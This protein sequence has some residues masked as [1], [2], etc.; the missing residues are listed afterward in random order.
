MSIIVRIRRSV[1]DKMKEYGAQLVGDCKKKERRYENR[2]TSISLR[3][4]NN[5]ASRKD[6]S[7]T[8]GKEL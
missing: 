6:S 5:W 8:P 2:K 7:M 4:K 1:Q 3:A